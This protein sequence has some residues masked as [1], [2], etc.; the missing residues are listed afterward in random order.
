ML[1]RGVE[2]PVGQVARERGPDED[3]ER[4]GVVGDQ[5]YPGS[6]QQGLGALPGAEYPG[7][8]S[9]AQP[10]ANTSRACGPA[11]RIVVRVADTGTTDRPRVRLHVGVP[12]AEQT[13]DPVDRQPFDHV[14][15]L[16]AAV[17]PPPGIALGVLVGQH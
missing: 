4:A 1:E 12:G 7:C 14:D 6:G 16:A 8:R 9:S 2:Q 3:P 13:G 11:S 10:C 5:Q 17:V 15:V